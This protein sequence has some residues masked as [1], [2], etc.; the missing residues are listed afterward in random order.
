MGV[1]SGTADSTRQ[2]LDPTE[3][4]DEHCQ[5]YKM[6]EQSETDFMRQAYEHVEAIHTPEYRSAMR[7]WQNGLSEVEL[8]MC[9]LMSLLS[10]CGSFS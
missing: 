5:S 10:L 7:L 8:L 6:I 4:W 9:A 2:Y 3:E 1:V